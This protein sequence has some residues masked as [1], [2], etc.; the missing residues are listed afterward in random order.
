MAASAHEKVEGFFITLDLASKE[1][2]ESMWVVSDEAN[3]LSSVVV[4][5]GD[6]SVTIR[7]TVMEIPASEREPFYEE[8]LR[9]NAE[10][11]RGAYALEQNSVILIDSLELPSLDLE[12]F[13]ASLESMGLALA[14]HY[15]RLARYRATN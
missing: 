1:V 14:Q 10:M 8:L 3:G 6:D 7:A 5:A 13:Q 9:L 11:V 4:Y 2:G 12:R 15:A